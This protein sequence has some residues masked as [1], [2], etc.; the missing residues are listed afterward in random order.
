MRHILILTIILFSCGTPK[1]D[2]PKRID[3]YN[4]GDTITHVLG[5]KI[6]V[7]YYNHISGIVRGTYLDNNGK[8]IHD[9]FS[10]NEIKK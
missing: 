3:P 6:V 1:R 7:T 5:T 8:L 10:L 2:R 4:P 9:K